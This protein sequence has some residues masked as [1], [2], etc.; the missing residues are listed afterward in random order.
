MQ[1]M[2]NFSEKRLDALPVLDV[3]IFRTNGHYNAS[4]HTHKVPP[5]QKK[6]H[7]HL[8]LPALKS[9]FLQTEWATNILNF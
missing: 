5:V 6:L 1:L 7:Y 8:V 4:F 3:D 9:N 2:F